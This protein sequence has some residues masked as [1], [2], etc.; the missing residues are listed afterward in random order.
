MAVI[1][2]VPFRGREPQ[3]T[4]LL[5]MLQA[6]ANV[7]RVIVAEPAAGGP[8]N[9]GLV[10]N[11]GF[12]AAGAA[13][14]DTVYFHDVDLLHGPQFTGLTPVAP[15]EVRHVYGHAHCL[16]GI[17]GMQAA[18]FERVNGFCTH[19][20]AWGLEDRHLREACDA[21]G[22]RLARGPE[23]LRFT[24]DAVV[25]EMD[26]R[27]NVL[28]GPKAARIF[29]SAHTAPQPARPR[30]NGHLAQTRVSTMRWYWHPAMPK[31][32]LVKFT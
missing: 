16:G 26:A 7:G 12:M 28:S 25:A 18:V 21:H 29:R 4:R 8:F 10:K 15:N 5:P 1:V 3:L 13:P 6:D 2:I 9:R 20:A 22:V 32:Q 27:G 31:V 17:V 24:N 23:V 11:V 14:G 19:R 30:L